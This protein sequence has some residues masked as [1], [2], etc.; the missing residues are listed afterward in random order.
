MVRVIIQ[1][2]RVSTWFLIQ[3]ITIRR[4]IFR[5]SIHDFSS[6]DEFRKEDTTGKEARVGELEI[7][8]R[9]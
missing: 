9:P 1:T 7:Q 2:E 6:L 3:C 5:E 8:A 4:E